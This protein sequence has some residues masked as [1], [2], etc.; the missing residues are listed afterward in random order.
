MADSAQNN[1]SPHYEN[2]TQDLEK[3]LG[4]V[5][6]ALISTLD[7]AVSMQTST[8]ENYVG[9]LRRKNPTASP[10]EIQELID[11]HFVRLASGSGASAGAAAAIPGIGLATGSAAIAGE[12]VLFL[13][14]A[15]FYTV[16]S[17]HLRGVDIRNPERRRALVLLT[18]LGAKGVAVIE[19][20]VG[21]ISEPGSA[22]SFS[23]GTILGKFSAPTLSNVN[24]RLTKMALKRASKRMM[25]SW[26]GKIMPLGIGA[27]LGGIANRRLASELTQNSATSL[28]P[29]PAQFTTPVPA[30]AAQDSTRDPSEKKN[31]LAKLVSR[32]RKEDDTQSSLTGDAKDDAELDRLALSAMTE[33]QQNDNS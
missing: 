18:L 32:F 22:G 10:Q 2:S 17:A 8:I 4:G 30:E 24:N 25:R 15:A 27:V 11:T 5:G 3:N 14:A 19:A 9:R 29:V 16:A 33:G 26:F 21:D 23:P 31:R 12:S 13:D 1:V 28:G 6:K 7:R 20:L